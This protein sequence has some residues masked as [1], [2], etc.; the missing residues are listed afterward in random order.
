MPTGLNGKEDVLVL[1]QDRGVQGEAGL[2]FV[3]TVTG[4]GAFWFPTPHSTVS[5]LSQ[6]RCPAP[7]AMW[8]HLA[9]CVFSPNDA[10]IARTS[11][12]LRRRT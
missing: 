3:C 4:P 1:T 2:Q 11:P 9:V 5:A 10:M 7:V 12:T 8:L 6:T